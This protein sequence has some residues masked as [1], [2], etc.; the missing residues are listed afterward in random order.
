MKKM[1]YWNQEYLEEKINDITRRIRTEEEI[2]NAPKIYTN[3]KSE[4]LLKNSGRSKRVEVEL[5]TW[6]KQ[7]TLRKEDLKKSLQP[8]FQPQLCSKS[9]KLAR[10]R[11]LGASNMQMYIH[12]TKD[13]KVQVVMLGETVLALEA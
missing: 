4:R 5:L 3:K 6:G 8:S 1:A 11:S 13:L 7:S 10:Q 9:L 2:R 12:L